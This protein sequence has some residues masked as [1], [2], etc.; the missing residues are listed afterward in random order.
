[1]EINKQQK[2]RTNSKKRRVERQTA[3][4]FQQKTQAEAIEHGTRHSGEQVKTMHHIYT[5]SRSD[6]PKRVRGPFFWS[7]TRR[8]WCHTPTTLLSLIDIEEA[9]RQIGLSVTSLELG[10]AHDLIPHHSVEG[11]L[12]FDLAE[13]DRWLYQHHF[14]ILRAQDNG[15]W[16]QDEGLKP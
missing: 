5:Q 1:M 16:D 13:L 10:A 11:Q 12:L 3:K 8:R 6:H 14:H 9:S 4:A 15:D 2:A 7:E